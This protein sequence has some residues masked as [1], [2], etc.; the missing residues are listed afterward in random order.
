MV[1]QQA[2]FV[3]SGQIVQTDAQQFQQP[4]VAGDGACFVT[5]DET[6]AREFQPASSQSGG[7]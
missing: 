6:A 1:E 4:F 2:V 5:G 3:T 7:A